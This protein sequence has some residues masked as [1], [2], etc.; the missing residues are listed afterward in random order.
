[1]L[2]III[3]LDSIKFTPNNEFFI[4]GFDDKSIKI[5]KTKGFE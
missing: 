3:T 4:T 1:M 5:M 2:I